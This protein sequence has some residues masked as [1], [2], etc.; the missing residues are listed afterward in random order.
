METALIKRLQHL[1][2][3]IVLVTVI[4]ACN[5]PLIPEYAQHGGQHKKGSGKTAVP[6]LRPRLGV[7]LYSKL[8]YSSARVRQWGERDIKYIAQDLHVTNISISWNLFAPFNHSNQVMAVRRV[9]RTGGSKPGSVQLGS[10]LTPHNLSILTSIAKNYGAT[11]EFR[12]LVKIE[13]P[14]QWSGYIA[15]YNVETWFHN[16]FL[17][18]LP[19]LRLAQQAHVREFI[20]GTE[21]TDLEKVA[22]KRGWGMFVRAVR[23]VYHGEI[24]YTAWE[25]H[26][27]KAAKRALPP[28]RPYGLAAYPDFTFHAVHCPGNPSVAQLVS[29][30]MKQFSAVPAWLRTETTI[31]E[32][33]IP[34]GCGAWRAP[35]NWNRDYPPD[36]T[37]QARWFTSACIAV[38]RLGLRGV[39]F[40]NVNLAD[41][42]Y[43]PSRSLTSFEGKAGARAIRGCRKLLRTSRS[44]RGG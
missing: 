18:E 3:I 16:Y 29:R 32:L 33:G 20:I 8:N 30:W 4:T 17:A 36:Q 35:W 14:K 22:T 10:S 38:A 12:P 19:Y 7:D 43:Y 42:P 15:P 23:S 25:G 26:Y 5:R 41:N 24:S 11:V 2:G 1:L 21:L 6:P 39:Y 37:A 28:I 27:Y 31:D 9:T 44:S 40:W 13:G 34:A